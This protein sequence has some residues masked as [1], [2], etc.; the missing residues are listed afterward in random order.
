MSRNA[1]PNSCRYFS[2]IGPAPARLR[3]CPQGSAWKDTIGSLNG[4][5]RRNRSTSSANGVWMSLPPGTWPASSRFGLV[6]GAI[7]FS[8]A[9]PLGAAPRRG[10]QVFAVVG[11]IGSG[12]HSRRRARG[13]ATAMPGAGQP[14]LNDRCHR[15]V[16]EL[17]R[18]RDAVVTAA[19]G[20]LRH[21]LAG[22]REPCRWGWPLVRTLGFRLRVGRADAGDEV[23]A[24]SDAELAE[25]VPEVELDGFDAD[26]QALP[27]RT[28][29][30][31]RF[32]RLAGGAQPGGR[33]RSPAGP[34][35]VAPAGPRRGA[36]RSRTPP[37]RRQPGG[38]PRWPD[39]RA[40]A[41][42][43]PGPTAARP[44]PA[45]PPAPPGRFRPH[46]GGPGRSG[47]RSPGIASRSGADTLGNAPCPWRARPRPH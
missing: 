2:P 47:R 14:L 40:A 17:R 13:P 36:R 44:V 32:P 15:G 22:P 19:S 27:G 26:V 41:P 3:P 24:G 23:F 20:G 1:S 43:P 16:G 4:R 11:G 42:R 35:P 30:R 46:R 31:D 10:G 38:R 29:P 33:Q 34:V 9:F 18:P 21:I 25:D 8:T 5:V 45:P 37:R 39:H 7:S 12:T 28:Q 6:R